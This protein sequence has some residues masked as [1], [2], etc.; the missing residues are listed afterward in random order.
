MVLF[1]KT[2]QKLKAI[3]VPH[4]VVLVKGV[5]DKRED[6]YNILV[7]NAIDLKKATGG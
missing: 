2:H 5:I 3:L 7:D 4:T 1:P 6:T